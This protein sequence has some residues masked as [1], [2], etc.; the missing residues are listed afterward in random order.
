VTLR[1]SGFYPSDGIVLKF[2]HASGEQKLVRGKYAR[3]ATELLVTAQAPRFVSS[4]EGRVEVSIS[5]EEGA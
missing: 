3:T 5:F 1:G 4:A 2:T